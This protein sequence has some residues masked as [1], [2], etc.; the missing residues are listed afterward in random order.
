LNR[1][2][3]GRRTPFKIHRYPRHG[4]DIHVRCCARDPEDSRRR[5]NQ[6]DGGYNRLKIGGRSVP[7]LTNVK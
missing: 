2:D 5:L 1:L 4:S 3:C 6:L 7:K